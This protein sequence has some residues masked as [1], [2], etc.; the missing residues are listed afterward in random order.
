MVK[1]N[2]DIL[3][4]NYVNALCELKINEISDY[5]DDCIL[6]NLVNSN[7]VLDK[8]SYIELLIEKLTNK[9]IKIDRCTPYEAN[10]G[11]S[12]ITLDGIKIVSFYEFDSD[13]KKIIKLDDY[14]FKIF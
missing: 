12:I 10:K 1:Y 8:G 11:L 14:W 6:I 7:E 5:L 2:K 13:N 4:Y 3:L 9:E